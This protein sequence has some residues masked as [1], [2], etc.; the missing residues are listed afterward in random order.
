[1]AGHEEYSYI[2]FV[3]QYNNATTRD[4]YTRNLREFSA[5]LDGQRIHILAVDP[6]DIIRY[7]DLRR[8]TFAPS[9]CVLTLRTLRLYYRWLVNRGTITKSPAENIKTDVVP[10]GTPRAASPDDIRRMLNVAT[11]DRNWAILSI[12]AFNSFRISELLGC[13][14]SDLEE[15]DGIEMLHFRTAR[16]HNRRPKAVVLAEES[17]AA[18]HRYLDGR[19]SGPLFCTRTGSRLSRH[20]ATGVV[21]ID[22]AKRAGLPYKVTP[23]M[24]TNAL[25]MTAIR[26]GFSFRGVSRAIGI[27]DRRH[28][29]R[30]IASAQGPEEDNASLRFARLVL[31]PPETTAN[32]LLH[33]EAIQNETDLPEPFVV[34]SAGAVF[35]RHLRQLCS[36]LNLPID[37]DPRSGKISEYIHLLHKSKTITVNERRE[38]EQIGEDRNNSAHG[39]FELLPKDAGIQTLR[40]V[41]NFLVSHPVPDSAGR[42]SSITNDASP[43]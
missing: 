12:A 24:V 26:Q 2:A 18:L 36:M 33:V 11:N 3:G 31:N 10:R 37:P 34:M 1:V 39:R 8:Q 43:L 30:W 28:S 7:I 13:N 38:A 22:A 32:M 19:Q 25:P 14:V 5:W 27:P 17:T 29:E 4:V 35:E 40:K 9:T 23:D 15:R 16:H 42:G 6:A 20:G 41:Q 21:F